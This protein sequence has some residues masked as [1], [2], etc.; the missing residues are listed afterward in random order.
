[1]EAG[2]QLRNQIHAGLMQLLHGSS[3]WVKPP[4]QPETRAKLFCWLY[5]F[6]AD[7][8]RHKSLTFRDTLND[9]LCA[10]IECLQNLESAFG[11][12]LDGAPPIKSIPKG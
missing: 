4:A 11:A 5:E 1:M 8:A 6:A 7:Q 3:Y 10:G 2:T 9:I 12:A